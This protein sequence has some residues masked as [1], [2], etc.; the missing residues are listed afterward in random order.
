[1]NAFK[2]TATFDGSFSE[3]ETRFDQL[4]DTSDLIEAASVGDL[5]LDAAL[6]TSF[7]TGFD[8]ASRRTITAESLATLRGPLAQL[9]GGDRP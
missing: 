6:P 5:A 9:P 3:R 1:M 4:F 8:V 2:L 7:E